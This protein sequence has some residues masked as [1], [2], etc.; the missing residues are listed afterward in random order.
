MKTEQIKVGK[1]IYLYAVNI[2]D[3]VS[4]HILATFLKIISEERKCKASRFIDFSDKVRSIVG[5]VILRYALWQQYGMSEQNIKFSYNEYGKPNLK[6][7]ENIFFNISHSGVWVFCAIGTVPLGVDIEKITTVDIKIA[8]RFFSK[9]EYKYLQK[10]PIEK[11]AMEFFKIWT[12]KESYIKEIGK[13]LSIP[14]N[15]FFFDFNEDEIIVCDQYGVRTDLRFR[16]GQ[17]ETEYCY[18]VCAECDNIISDKIQV[19]TM[20]EL[21]NFSSK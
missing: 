3:M 10:Q 21:M 12:L 1:E 6:G 9:N 19:V 17:M 8:Q 16:V 15:S 7:I 18:A 4:E 20:Q 5:E 13:G 2:E 14:L 11:R